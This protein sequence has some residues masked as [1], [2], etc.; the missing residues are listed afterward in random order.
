VSAPFSNGFEWDCWSG[1]WCHTCLMDSMGAPSRAP[2][3]FCPIVTDAMLGETP[4]AWTEVEPD[5]LETRYACSEYA[6]REGEPDART[7]AGPDAMRP[8][9]VD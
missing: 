5:G 3:V 4:G 8:T 2:E 9:P 6:P 7:L 1:R